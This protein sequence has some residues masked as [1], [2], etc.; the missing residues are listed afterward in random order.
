MVQ[1]FGRRVHGGTLRN[2]LGSHESQFTG[3]LCNGM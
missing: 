2:F 1:W 3:L